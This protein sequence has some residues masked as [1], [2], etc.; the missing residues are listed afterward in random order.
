MDNYERRTVMKTNAC[1]K[2]IDVTSSIILLVVLASPTSVLMYSQ[3]EH[4]EHLKTEDLDPGFR[5]TSIKTKCYSIPYTGAQLKKIEKNGGEEIEELRRFLLKKTEDDDLSL[6]VAPLRI[7]LGE[8][9]SVI[10]LDLEDPAVE[11]DPFETR[12]V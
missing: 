2:G 3:P 1:L 7:I 11:F 4:V 5:T 6:V 10:C 9:S 12:I 8:E